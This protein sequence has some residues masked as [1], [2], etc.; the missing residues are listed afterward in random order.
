MIFRIPSPP[1]KNTLLIS[2]EKISAECYRRGEGR[3]WLYYPYRSG[4]A[5]SLESFG[6][7]I[8]IEQLYIGIDFPQSPATPLNT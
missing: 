8:A 5:I 2:S 7:T 4:D 6:L 1:C 3:M